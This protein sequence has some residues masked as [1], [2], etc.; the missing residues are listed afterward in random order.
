MEEQEKVCKAEALEHMELQQRK[1]SRCLQQVSLEF[2]VEKNKQ[3]AFDHP[4]AC[5]IKLIAEMIAVK[6]QPFSIV[7]DVGFTRLELS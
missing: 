5:E 4:K 3:L 2:V 1:Q 7:S 6:D